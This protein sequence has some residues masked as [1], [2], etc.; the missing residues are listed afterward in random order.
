M[1][2][3]QVLTL[4]LALSGAL[5]T[6][7][8]AGITA[9]RAGASPPRPSLPLPAPPE[10]SWPFSSPPW[11]RTTYNQ[12]ATRGWLCVI[13]A[14]RCPGPTPTQADLPPRV[15][16]WGLWGEGGALGGAADRSSDG[17]PGG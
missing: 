10:P 6:A 2:A 13:G 1:H 5:N 17:G 7:F 14:T 4:I 11:P 8:A 15:P 3:M 16:G 9:R 12:A